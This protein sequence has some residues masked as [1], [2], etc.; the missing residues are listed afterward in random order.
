ME[1]TQDVLFTRSGRVSLARALPHAL[2]HVIAAFAGIVTPAIIIASV[3]GFTAQEEAA[4][5][6]ASLVLSALD[7]FLQQFPIKGRIGSGLPII[8]GASF[9]FV[10]ALKAVGLELGFEAVLGAQIVGGVLVV[11]FGLMF[12]RLSFLFP[13]PVLG[14]VIFVIG[15]SL[16]PVAVTSMAGGDGAADFGSAANWAVALVTFVVTFAAGNYG[17]GALKLGSILCGIAAG[18]ALA[19]VLGMVDF[20]SVGSASWFALPAVSA[21]KLVFDPAACAVVGVVAIVNAVQVMGELAAVSAAGLDEPASDA[22][23]SGGLVANGLVGIL[24]GFIG[25]VPTATFGQNVG[26]IAENKVVNRT[27]FTVAASILL[28]AGLLPKCAAVLTSIPQPV[29]GGATIGVFATIGMNGVVMFA[30]EGLSQRDTTLMGLSIAFGT[31]I[32]HTAGALAGPGFPTWVATVF[33][34]S[35]IAVTAVV[36][37]VLNLVLPRQRG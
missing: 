22:Q 25:G 26:I 27:V 30:R 5:I 32:E 34:G 31:G 11:I 7:I 2:Q 24:S 23:I 19:A 36:A 33:G 37:V 9:T 16:C 12:R 17:R 20:S 28:I 13:A 1:E 15:L 29:I 10:P 4:V 8:M 6:Q 21:R 14:T 3:C 35:A 18:F